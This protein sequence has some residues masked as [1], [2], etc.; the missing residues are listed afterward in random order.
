MDPVRG[1]AVFPALRVYGAS[2]RAPVLGGLAHAE[3][4]YYDSRDDRDGTD[5]LTRN[6][7]W[8]ALAGFEREVVRNCTAA[9]QAYVERMRD[10]AAYRSGL[11]PGASPRDATR[12]VL[13]LRITWLLLQQ[14]LRLGAI[15]LWSPSDEDVHIRPQARYAVSDRLTIEGGATLSYGREAHTFYGQFEQNNVLYTSVRYGF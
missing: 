14:N 10:H 15:A 3:T 7:E 4:G 9:A 12:S 13:S 2:A 8:R 6:S 1:A 5:P 11:P